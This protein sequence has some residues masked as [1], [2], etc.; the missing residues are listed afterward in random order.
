MTWRLETLSH[1]CATDVRVANL[2][3]ELWLMEEVAQA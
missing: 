2:R 1:L 3:R